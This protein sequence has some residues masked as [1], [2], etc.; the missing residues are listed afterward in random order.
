[1]IVALV[2]GIIMV[3]AVILPLSSEY[4]KAKTFKNEGYFTM[5]KYTA[6]DEDLTVSWDHT[7]PDKIT[8]GD[9]EITVSIP[10]GKWVSVVVGDNWYFRYVVSNSNVT[11]V[12]MSYGSVAVITAATDNGRDLEVTLS[13]GTA[14]GKTYSSGVV[15]STQTASYTE[16][17][18]IAEDGEY[19]IMKDSDVTATMLNDSE[20]IG[21]GQTFISG[22]AA[23]IKVQGTIDD[24]ATVTIIGSTVT[25]AI[26]TDTISVNATPVNG[27]IDCYD[28][29]SIT[30][31]VTTSGGT[32]HA[33]Y[34]YFI[35]PAE[36]TA[37]PDNPAAYK[38][39][40]MVIPLMAFVV[41]VVAAAAMIYWKKD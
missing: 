18:V 40:V 25:A 5:N 3:T 26:D 33:T 11:E 37:D 28:L 20:F 16:V 41:L 2:I 34:N 4:S 19:Y 38:S 7:K 30:F 17:Y 14:T 23:I 13:N 1:M 35:V 21:I 12:Q 32:T 10:K 39:L 31:D 29:T 9:D 22:G 8:V 36:V 27:Y 6:D 24:G 15:Q